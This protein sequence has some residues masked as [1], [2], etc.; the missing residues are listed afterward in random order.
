MA[1][2]LAV[3]DSKKGALGWE[4]AVV[5]RTRSYSL[6]G[7]LTIA[8]LGGGFGYWAA[9]APLAGAAVAPGV[10][11]AAGQN[12]FVQHLDGGIIKEIKVREGD[13]VKAGEPLI[14]LDSTEAMSQL[15]RFVK[16]LIALKAKAARLEAE[17]D[18]AQEMSLALPSI[19]SGASIDPTEVV[20]EQRKEFLARLSRYRTEL[21]I[22]EQRIAALNEAVEGLEAQ[23][24]AG[25]EQLAVVEEEIVRKKGLLDKG[26]TDRSEYTAL[27][28]AQAELVGQI[29]ALQSQIA[30]ASIQTVEAREQIERLTTAR[31]ENAVSEI[32]VVRASIADVEEQ[33]LA[34][35]SVAQRMVIR[36]PADGI[37][38]RT[39]P[40]A[41]GGVVRPGEPIIEILPTTKDLIVEAR[42][43]VEDI[44][45]VRLGQEAQLRFSALNLRRTPEVPGT[46][47]YVSADRRVDQSTQQAFYTARLTMTKD[48]PPEVSP[49][50]IYPGMPVEAFIST[51]DRTFFEYLLKPIQDSFSR[52]FREE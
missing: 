27:L 8:A 6:I 14:V 15:N 48:L 34:S 17:R 1:G 40:N 7:Y 23:K 52:A 46:V 44:D 16:Q 13:R 4:R 37:V 2:A 5:T 19:P 12:I 10:V 28:R 21:A 43:R 50:Q 29:G 45:A 51:G 11:A 49:E 32:N 42:L 30:S 41:S 3:G 25:E 26:L 39:V 9:T 47:T 31:I 18:G 38:V 36:A 22:L 33:L 24:K 35:A 20:L